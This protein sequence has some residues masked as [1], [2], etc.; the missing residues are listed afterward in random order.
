MKESRYNFNIY[1]TSCIY[2]LLDIDIGWAPAVLDNR[3]EF[4]FIKE[5]QRSFTSVPY[6][7]G[8]STNDRSG[9]SIAF[10]NYNV[11]NSGTTTVTGLPVTCWSLLSQV[12][13]H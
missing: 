10:R 11:D 8:G 2:L 7:I 13:M 9:S 1:T 12:K 5:G 6:W 3:R 4:N